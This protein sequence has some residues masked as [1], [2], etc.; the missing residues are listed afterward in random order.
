MRAVYRLFIILIVVFTVIPGAIMHGATHVAL[1]TKELRQLNEAIKQAPRYDAAARLRIDSL[2]NL[3]QVANPGDLNRRWHLCEDIA[4][5]YRRNNSDSALRYTYKCISLSGQDTVRLLESKLLIIDALSVSGLFVHALASFD[6]IQRAPMADDLK[7][8]MWRTGRQLY[9]YMM[10]YVASDSPVYEEYSRQYMAYDDSLLNH[11][12]P[13][14][15]FCIFLKAERAVA[16]GQY[17]EAKKSLTYLMDRLT[18][19]SN[20]Y[21]MTAYQMAVVYRNQGD[22]TNY[23]AYLAKAAISD[24]EAVVREGLALPELAN[25][26][27]EQGELEEAFDYITFALEGANSG[28]VRMRSVT[29]A[30]LVPLIDQA[31]RKEIQASRD[32]WILWFLLTLVL[33]LASGV[34]LFYLRRQIRDSRNTHRKLESLSRR[35]ESY[36]GNFVGLCSSYADRL[37]SLSRLVEVKVSSG[38]TSELLKLVKSGRFGD[39]KN[40]DF[41]LRFDTAFLDLYPDFVFR[42]NSLLRDEEQIELRKG[43]LLTPELRI[44]AFVKLGVSE[45]TKIAQILHYSVSTI[46]AYR[47]K[48]RNKAINRETFDADILAMPHQ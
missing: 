33:L 29:I 12:P 40:E 43:E 20:L 7:I 19:A 3:L 38:K 30:A 18:P 21:G 35:Q 5:L 32:R 45:S 17:Q 1:P 6:S 16:R 47:N 11:L 2:K 22:E 39:E 24:I 9:S 28:N 48:M 36:I 4:S 13:R 25:W 42:V 14:D 8:K 26:L 34:L 46:Y 23:A 15:N 31:Y 27:Y 44:Y 41:Y 37:D 10:A